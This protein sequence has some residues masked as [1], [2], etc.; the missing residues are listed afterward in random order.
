[1]LKFLL[2][3]LLILMSF[4]VFSQAKYTVSGYVKDVQNGETLI[5]ATILVKGTLTG[6]TSNVYGFYSLSLPAGNYELSYSYIGFATVTNTVN[7]D[8]NQTITIEL[9][10]DAEQLEEVIVTDTEDFDVQGIQMSTEKLPISTIKKIPALFGEVDVLKSIQLLPG[11]S[12]VGE[13]TSGFNVRGGG[14]GQNLVLL[15]DA[16]VYNSSHLFGFFSVFNPDAVK[17]VKLIKGGIPANYGGRLSSILD[18]RMKEGNAKELEVSGGVG[19]VFSRLAVQGPIKKKKASFII[20]GRRSYVD[21]LAK[22]FT[23]DATLY[24]YD[25]TTKVNYNINQ[26]NRLYLSGYFGRDIFK[27]DERQGFDWGSTTTTLRWNHLFNE[28]LFSNTSFFISK[29]DYGFSFGENDDDK[30]D[31]KSRILTYTIKPTFDYFINAN[32]ELTFGGEAIYYDFKPAESIGVSD[33]VSTDISLDKKFAL[34]NA[35]YIDNKQK[36]G[37]RITLRYGMRWSAFQYFGPG[38]VYTYQETEPGMRKEVVS[39][40]SVGDGTAIQSYHNMEPRASLSFSLNDR[41]SI[42]AS[43]TRTNQYVHLISNT[44]ASTPID[45]WTPSTNNIKPQQG[46]QYALGY[47]S[48]QI[49]DKELEFSSEVYYRDTKNQVEYVNGADLLI[50]ELIEG[51]LISGN[52]RAYGLELSVKKNSGKV[53][54]WISYTIS[55]SELRTEGINQDDWYPA[56]FDQLHNLT[57]FGNYD[58][59]DRSSISANFSYVTG[60]PVTAPTSR[61]EQQGL[62]IPF[63]YYDSRNGLRTPATHRLDLS[64]TRKLRKVKNGEKRKNTDELVISIYNVYARKN[65]FSIFFAQEQTRPIMTQSPVTQATQFSIIGSIIP[66]ISYNFNF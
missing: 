31:W 60:A 22:P 41:S 50:N 65:P 19:T 45:V 4:G 25:L 26:N 55:K 39:I 40:A 14:V 27:F 33:G 11:V 64:F 5:G 63:D 6:T 36:I 30:F 15:D 42:K 2:F 13:G 48:N 16:P 7:F 51:D 29:Y 52:G 18:V 17:D 49:G 32:N 28:R 54:G 23:G 10:S 53:N 44:A 57:V 37:D 47:F 3:I 62:V 46:D 35:L 43:Y 8:K 61:F 38:N 20:A 58:F 34:E 59:N 66:S 12:A 24:F 21:I 9:A 1:M 56:R